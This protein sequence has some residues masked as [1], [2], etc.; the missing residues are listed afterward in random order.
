MRADK[1]S[2]P[3]GGPLPSEEPDTDLLTPSSLNFLRAACTKH[4][5]AMKAKFKVVS[6]NIV[7]GHSEHHIAGNA[8]IAV[9]V[10][11]RLT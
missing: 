8:S 3:L 11:G 10:W 6:D 5:L 7:S 9:E 1:V 2:Y 4:K